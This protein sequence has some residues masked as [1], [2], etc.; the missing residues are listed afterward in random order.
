LNTLE[1]LQAS[2][3]D[4][5]TL[6]NYLK[7]N[8][9]NVYDLLNYSKHSYLKDL[10]D[11]LNRYILLNRQVILELDVKNNTNLSFISLL[12]SVSERL[13]LIST[14]RLLYEHLSGTDYYVGCRLEATSLYLIGIKSS[15]DYIN[16]YDEILEKLLFS[17]VNEED[18]ADK[19]LMTIVQYYS[20]VL[21]DFGQFNKNVVYD[22]QNKLLKSCG[23]L[24]YSFL[25]THLIR[26]ILKLEII[27]SQLA[28]IKLQKLLDSFLRRELARPEYK[29]KFLIEVDTDYEDKIRTIPSTFSCIRNLS[30]TLQNNFN[31]DGI[32]G[33]LQ[34]GVKILDTEDQ[35]FSYMKSYGKMHYQKNISSFKY[36]QGG[37]FKKSIN[38]VDWGCGQGIAS[39]SFFDYLSNRGVVQKI[40]NIY[41]IEPSILALKR[42]SLHVNKYDNINNSDI[43]TINK[44]LDS[45]SSGDID[46]SEDLATL[47][48][49][50]NILDIDSFSVTK[51]LDFIRNS[52]NGE[53]YFICVSPYINDLKT[54]RINSFVTSLTSESCFHILKTIDNKKGEWVNNWS[55]VIRVFSIGVN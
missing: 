21:A 37:F 30:V 8:F 46:G 29:N 25:D 15:A 41:L 35:L 2:T 7:N 36:L 54:S 44:D 48:L 16:R 38:I 19:V 22:L 40:N 24:K 9:Q 34:R 53:N 47:H 11:K 43:I 39:I 49:F 52:F 1:N 3:C 6:Q 26:E 17:F 12:L 51:L 5:F 42:A 55:R 13:G 10:T 14:F 28:Q 31:D 18:N 50:S 45:L 20:Q 4:V 33:S 32:F 23:E 27:D